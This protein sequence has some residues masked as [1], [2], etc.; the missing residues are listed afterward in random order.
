MQSF[1]AMAGTVRPT[2]ITAG[3]QVLFAAATVPFWVKVFS[4]DGY[5]CLSCDGGSLLL[6]KHPPQGGMFFVLRE[7]VRG[8]GRD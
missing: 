7:V 1:V 2:P 3:S 8:A 4:M 6:K 5:R